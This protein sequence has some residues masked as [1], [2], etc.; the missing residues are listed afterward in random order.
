MLTLMSLGHRSLYCVTLAALLAFGGS[1]G[2]PGNSRSTSASIGAA[3]GSLVGPGGVVVDV[4]AGAVDSTFTLVIA[5]LP[6]TRRPAAATRVGTAARLL[7]E[8]QTFL[9]PVDVTFPITLS[10]LPPGSTVDDVIVLRA[11]QDSN[12][13]VPLPT[14]R[15]GNAVVASTDHFSDFVA[16]VIDAD[17]G[18]PL[19]A[20]GSGRFTV[21]SFPTS[22]D[23]LTGL[24]WERPPNTALVD[25]ATA[26]ASCAALTTSTYTD[27]HLPT[28][29]D[30]LFFMDYARYNPA[31]DPVFT[32]PQDYVWTSTP[33]AGDATQAWAVYTWNGQLMN[34]PTTF[35]GAMAW[36][37][38]AFD[39]RPAPTFADNGDGTVTGLGRGRVWQKTPSPSGLDFNA[40]TAYCAGL[41]GGPWRLPT[42]IELHQLT[43]FDL[44]PQAI[45]T[46]IFDVTANTD[47]WSTTPYAPSTGE[48]WFWRQGDGS[49][50]NTTTTA[51]FTARC[52]K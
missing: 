40:A 31:V 36:C 27:W 5:S 4:P 45:D 7:P 6:G 34:Y 3:G 10:A 28:V 44:T 21:N 1:C 13:F 52:V 25:Q 11:P 26:A 43:R 19:D 39:A 8:G 35:T 17:A 46:A 12:V 33:L 18:S 38:H 41:A 50:G 15:V 29:Q 16:V 51:S 30:L 37:V 9:K 24:Q 47:Y 22:T 42:L 32:M 2:R 20:G 14:R 49:N 48:V 23:A